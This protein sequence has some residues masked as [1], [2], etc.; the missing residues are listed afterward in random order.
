MIL[1]DSDFV[2][3]LSLAEVNSYQGNVTDHNSA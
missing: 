2:K 3:S 1:Y